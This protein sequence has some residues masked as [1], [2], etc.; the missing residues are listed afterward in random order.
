MGRGEKKEGIEASREMK[1]KTK[2]LKALN[3]YGSSIK[4]KKCHSLF[5]GYYQAVPPRNPRKRNQRAREPNP[6]DQPAG[7]RG[8]GA[9]KRVRVRMHN[10]MSK[11]SDEWQN[12]C[13]NSYFR[14]LRFL[15]DMEY[16]KVNYHMG[17]NIHFCI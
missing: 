13:A 9:P 3:D 16:G 2:R 17:I 5:C 12:T 7:G 6:R 10:V 14:G 15:V 8:A 1:C 11:P 4:K